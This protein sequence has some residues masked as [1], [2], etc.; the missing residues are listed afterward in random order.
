MKLLITLVIL[1]AIY[2]LVKGITGEYKEKQAKEQ[3]AEAGVPADGLTGLPPQF[4]P[5]LQQAE[6]AGPA[7]L[8]AWLTRYSS[9]VEDPKLAAIQLDYVGM[10]GRSDPA[11]AKRIFK[12]VKARTPKTSLIYPRIQ[13]LDAT[14]GR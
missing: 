3:A 5:S 10:I 14:F 8:K 1:L 7:A 9:Y 13:K 2:F 4:E 12:A 6:A 11:E